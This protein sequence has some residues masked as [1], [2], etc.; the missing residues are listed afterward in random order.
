MDVRR[1][2]WREHAALVQAADT[3]LM[4]D[5]PD[6]DRLRR[7]GLSRINV[8]SVQRQVDHIH[9]IASEI[10]DRFV[11][12]GGG[13]FIADVALAVTM[14][15][16]SDMMGLPREAREW[17]VRDVNVRIQAFDPNVSDDELA[18][19]DEAAV[20]LKHF[21]LDLV[22]L[23]QRQPARDLISDLLDPG[24]NG[25]PLTAEEI[26]TFADFLFGAG[27]D[28]TVNTL[29]LGMLAFLEN[30]EQFERLREDASLLQSMAEE[31]LRYTTII[32]GQSR[33][34]TA[35]LQLGAE[36]IPEGEVLFC[37]LAAA[38]RDPNVF[39]DPD[40]FDIG[41]ADAPHMT[42]GFG[43][44]ICLGAPLA[45]AEIQIVF[46]LLAERCASLA[47]AVPSSELSL[48]P[49]MSPRGLTR[50]PLIVTSNRS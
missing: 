25:E 2:D 6:H 39:P 48:E 21:W 16:I 34:T 7:I 10:V 43:R 46:G 5:G 41:R 30:P 14:S 18:R 23:R 19:A 26:A 12:H 47:C 45:R 13:D 44:H 29:G 37:A 1:P 22:A 24:E 33:Y 32:V 31:V 20:R 17:Y 35:E 36:T 50:L 15:V 8:R 28:T 27:F 11:E 42:F 40:R 4:I 49:R 38:N 9:G 3:L